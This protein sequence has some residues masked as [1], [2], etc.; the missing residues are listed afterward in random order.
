VGE[1]LHDKVKAKTLFATHYHELT[2]LALTRPG[3]RNFRVDVREEKDRVVFL[4]RIVEGGADRS[5]GIQVARLA[6]L[7]GEVLQRAE[8]ILKGL[9]AGEL[10][11]AGK[12]A[13]I[14]PKGARSRGVARRD[15]LDLFA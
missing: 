15:E 2:E 5:Y 8:E 7:P 11:A 9:E 14:R 3:V 6:G 4:R 12:P 13:R 10:N 1:H